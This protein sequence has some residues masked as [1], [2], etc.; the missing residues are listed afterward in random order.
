[1]KRPVEM[2]R[3][4]APLPDA[5]AIVGTW[6]Y[7][8]YTGGA[9]YEMYTPGGKM[10]LMVPLQHWPATYSGKENALTLH[11]SEGTAT[12]VVKGD[13]LTLVSPDG[14]SSTYRRAPR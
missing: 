7:T 5:A 6:S 2:T 4:G 11:L 13:V 3:V 10:V 9:A 14:Q 8:H 1:M 12:V